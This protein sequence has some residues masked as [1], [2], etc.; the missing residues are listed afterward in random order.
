MFLKVAW[1]LSS[2]H[3]LSVLSR[4]DYL[5]SKSSVVRMFVNLAADVLGGTNAMRAAG[6][7]AGA[8]TAALD[9]GKG[10]LVGLPGRVIIPGNIWAKIAAVILAVLGRYSPFS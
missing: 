3:I 5:L 7:V 9:A 10:I 1:Q 8:L 6:F 4:S 2:F